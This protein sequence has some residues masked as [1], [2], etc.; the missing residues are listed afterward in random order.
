MF[1]EIS[2]S[3][4]II[5]NWIYNK[6]RMFSLGIPLRHWSVDFRKNIRI[7]ISDSHIN[8]CEAFIKT[9]FLLKQCRLDDSR[10]L[11]G[12]FIKFLRESHPFL[13][14][15]IKSGL[16]Y[17]I[18]SK[19]TNSNMDVFLLF[20]LVGRF[21]LDFHNFSLSLLTSFGWVLKVSRSVWSHD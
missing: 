20:L 16:T 13:R 4:N 7:L 9:I 6:I 11:L 5:L 12:S 19:L 10:V 1:L 14:F 15:F 2:Q 18:V 21:I 3:I 8:W 17:T